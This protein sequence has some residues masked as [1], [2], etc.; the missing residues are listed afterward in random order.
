L[1]LLRSSGVEYEKI[2]FQVLI[3][4]IFETLPEFRAHTSQVE[5]TLQHVKQ[6]L[7]ELTSH[8]GKRLVLLFDDAAHIGREASLQEF[9]DIFRTLSSSS[10]SC[11][12]AIY[13]GVTRFG[14]RFDIYNDATTI[15]LFRNE[16]TADYDIFFH[17]VLTTRYPSFEQKLTYSSGLNATKVAGFLARCVLGNMRGYIFAANKLGEVGEKGNIDFPALT[18][19]LKNLSENYYWP[20]LEELR[21]KLGVYEPM[22]APAQQIAEILFQDAADQ[23]EST[24]VLVFKDI[25]GNLAKPI[26]LLE[27][28]GFLS[29]REASKAMK[30]GGRGVRY[31][32]NLCNLL[33]RVRGARL[34]R[35]IFSSWS[36]TSSVEPIEFHR[37]SKLAGL[38][39]PVPLDKS[40]L[41]VLALDITSL[42]QSTANSYWLTDQKIEVLKQA[43]LTTI[44]QLA[45]ASDEQLKDIPSIGDVMKTRIRN[46]VGQAIWM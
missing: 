17:S 6:L 15:D 34:T 10:V 24:S 43:G 33:E 31:Q 19:V 12:A 37:G 39:V 4:R 7:A 44:G 8:Y 25:V 22:L 16:T 13:P 45:D 26:E 9:F 36:A 18:E 29:R 2:F 30:S 23:R 35:E 46:V 40:D 20:L 32:L 27:Y 1:P 21:P 14:T 38:T 28:A 11:K 5:P 42:R 3:D 41:G